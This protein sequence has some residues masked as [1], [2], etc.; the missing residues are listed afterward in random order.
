[1]CGVHDR[2]DLTNN[3]GDSIDSI[4][5][6]AFAL[7]LL[8]LSLPLA[9]Q[10]PT[11]SALLPDRA[12]AKR[13]VELLEVGRPIR[14]FCEPCGDRYVQEVRVMNVTLQEQQDEQ[15][16]RWSVKINGASLPI[17]QIYFRQEG[18]W[19]NLAHAIGLDTP[20]VPETIYPFF[21]ARPVPPID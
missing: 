18:K 11:D 7:L 3:G 14:L 15:D 17:N 10:E 1:M 13:A 4:L 20:G 2:A 21:R 5:R 12:T 6:A 9:S 19:R 8:F 16:P